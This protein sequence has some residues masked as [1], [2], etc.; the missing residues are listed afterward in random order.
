MLQKNSKKIWSNY[1][2]IG[3]MEILVCPQVL[4]I[5]SILISSNNG[6]E[7]KRRAMWPGFCG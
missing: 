3:Y 6:K 7:P 1:K 5:F 4:Q 2:F